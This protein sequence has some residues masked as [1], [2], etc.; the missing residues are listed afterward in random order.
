[1][2][3]SLLTQLLSAITLLC[4]AG[5]VSL[6]FPFAIAKAATSCTTSGSDSKSQVLNGIGQV[7]PDCSTTKA[8]T[9]LTSAAVTIL[10]MVVG[11][12]AVIMIVYAGLKY[13]TSGGDSAK[14]GS[15]KNTLVYA[16]I[17][18]V[19]AVL[20]QVM[21]HFVINTANATQTACPTNSKIAK[22]DA[23]CKP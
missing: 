22:S 15:A 19:V 10:S 9:S 2:K 20:A 6:I 8:Q 4:V 7:A 18:L 21:V 23:A 12:L 16:L 3:K 14:V 11:I 1:M 5:A 17:G 13:V